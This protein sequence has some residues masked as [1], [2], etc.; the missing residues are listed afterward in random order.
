MQG[1][2]G[3]LLFAGALHV[4]LEELLDLKWVIGTLASVGVVLST[5]ITGT[6]GYCLF[7]LVGL[8]LSL[9]YCLLFGALIAP[10]DPIAVMGVLKAA[11]LPKPLEIKIVGE[12]LFNDGV[13]VV[14]FLVLLSL[15]P[16]APVNLA[17]VVALLLKEAIGGALLAGHSDTSP[18]RC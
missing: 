6:L 4:N 8:H 11:R 2:L 13:G 14:V 15:V 7:D 9:I 1:M 3:C 5:L 18:T 17:G 10:T 12:S 16:S